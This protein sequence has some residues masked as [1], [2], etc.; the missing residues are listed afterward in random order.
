MHDRKNIPKTAVL[1]C[2]R[3]IL[4]EN[5]SKSCLTPYISYSYI[6]IARYS[7]LGIPPPTPHRT[8]QTRLNRTATQARTL[9]GTILDPD[10]ASRSTP[11]HF[12]SG[13]IEWLGAPINGEDVQTEAS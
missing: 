5:W 8:L 13:Y 9:S 4:D 3:G 12:F 11:R 1:G 2:L 7:S 6:I 10:F